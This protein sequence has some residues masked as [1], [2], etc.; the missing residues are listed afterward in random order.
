M[1]VRF[2]WVGCGGILIVLASLVAWGWVPSS[3]SGANCRLAENGAWISV[4]WT[5]QPV[6]EAAVAELA[7]HATV[8]GLRYLFPYTT[9]VKPDGTFSPSC[10]HAAEFVS[11]FRQH[12]RGTRLLAWVGIPL[13]NDGKLGIQGWVDLFDEGD[14]Q[15]IAAFVEELVDEADF[16]G[17][18]L[19]VETVR[20]GDASYLLLL[21]E[22]RRAIGP[23]RILSVAG[24]YWLPQ[25]LNGLPFVEGLKWGSKYYEAVASRVDQIA[26]M[27]YDSLMPH[28]ALYRLWLREQVR[29]IGR[30]LA[31]SEVEL[32]IGIS[33]SRERTTTHRPNAENMQSGLV[34]ACAG[35]HSTGRKA[36]G[37]AVYAAWEA[38]EADWQMWETWLAGTD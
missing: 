17:V 30:S 6:N 8:R 1:S 36:G 26:T 10:G 19:N 15:A 37:I 35:L 27:T 12:N 25:V 7:E 23:E 33:A 38:E 28:P 31:D 4:A 13:K 2:R 32:L 22:V 3:V 16:D 21:E 29:G 24:S 11:Q 34:G 18:H 5:S 9:Y 14:R 20:D